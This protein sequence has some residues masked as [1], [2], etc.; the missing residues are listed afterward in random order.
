MSGWQQLVVGQLISALQLIRHRDLPLDSI[1]VEN[2]TLKQVILQRFKFNTEKVHA[3]SVSSDDTRWKPITIDSST[4]V[5]N[6]GVKLSPM[7]KKR[8]EKTLSS[9]GGHSLKILSRTTSSFFSKLTPI[10]TESYAAVNET[11]EARV[12]P[13]P[14]WSTCSPSVS[15]RTA[16]RKLNL[17]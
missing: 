5:K 15:N 14:D 7:V 1:R 12:P 3:S 16:R 4:G 2:Y 9:D 8:L 10:S 17:V 13:I 6:E 11:A